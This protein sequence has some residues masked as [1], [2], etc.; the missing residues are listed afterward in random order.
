MVSRGAQHQVEPGRKAG[1]PVPGSHTELSSSSFPRD[2]PGRL[3]SLQ[4]DDQC[5]IHP[6]PKPPWTEPETYPAAVIRVG[7]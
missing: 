6:E 3:A 2:V 1:V 4:V 5:P 7:G